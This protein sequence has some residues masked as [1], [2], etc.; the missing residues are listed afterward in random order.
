MSSEG[1]LFLTIVVFK[2]F[3][4]RLFKKRKANTENNPAIHTGTEWNKDIL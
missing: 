4:T 1:Q 2:M 3:L